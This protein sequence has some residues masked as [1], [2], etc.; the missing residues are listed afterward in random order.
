MT[1]LI[2]WDPFFGLG[3]TVRPRSRHVFWQ[4]GAR[5]AASMTPRLEF[6][7]DLSETEDDV[8]VKASLPGFELSEL[9]VSVK[10]DVLTIKAEHRDETEE[11]EREFY[12]REIRYGAARR[13]V[14]L[15]ASVDAEKTEA[16]FSNGLLS[17]RLPKSEALKSKQITI[18]ASS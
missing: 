9:D 8:E 14:K 4:P 12:R 1:N 2:R 17:L 5:A 11:K 15:P 10:D 16:S 18:S 3:T 6:P 13:A 7:I